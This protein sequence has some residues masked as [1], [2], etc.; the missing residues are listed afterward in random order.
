[1]AM[2]TSSAK[3]KGR[4]LQQWMAQ[5]ISSMTGIPCGK[6][7]LIETREMGQAGVDVKLIGVAREKFPF[8]IECKNQES[9]SVPAYVKQAKQNIMLGTDWLLVMQRKDMDPV[10]CM[11]AGAFMKLMKHIDFPIVDKPNRLRQK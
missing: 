9:W 2:K 1:M 11:D 5:K 8:S 6:D 7:E 4:R 3:A 10:V